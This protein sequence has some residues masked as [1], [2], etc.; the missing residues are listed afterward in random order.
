M[1]DDVLLEKLLQKYSRLDTLLLGGVITLKLC[2]TILALEK[3]EMED[4]YGELLMAQAIKGT[5][6]NS[7]KATPEVEEFIRERMN[8]GANHYGLNIDVR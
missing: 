6:N 8:K 2:R 1:F 3:W 5:S 4:L 7:F